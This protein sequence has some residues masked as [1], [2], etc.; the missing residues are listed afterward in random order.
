MSYRHPRF[1]KEDYGAFGKA[2][3]QNFDEQF[4]NVMDYY[5]QQA[6]A[7]KEYENDLFAQADKMREDAKAAGATAA[8]LK[9]KIE[10]QVQVFLKEGLE[11]KGLDKPGFL[12]MN[13]KETGKK[14]R[15]QLD[16][17]NASF[18]ANIQAANQITDRA[19]V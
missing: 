15:L 12:G 14:N 11:V 5:D 8:D 3:Q 6:A 13:I 17:A 9:G 18:N 10:D 2:F 16:E 7:R 19:F 1:Y 4:N